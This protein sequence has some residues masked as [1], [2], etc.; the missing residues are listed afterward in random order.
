MAVS[1]EL[2]K[3]L[4]IYVFRASLVIVLVMKIIFL[5]K[6]IRL[7]KYRVII[8]SGG[9][10]EEV[11]IDRTWLRPTFVETMSCW[12]LSAADISTESRI[13][14][15]NG[16]NSSQHPRCISAI[17]LFAWSCQLSCSGDMVMSLPTGRSSTP[18][19][20]L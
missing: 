15:M 2:D 9:S 17:P 18:A 8:L 13:S 12:S 4:K 3:V 10:Q 16:R 14:R 20:I 7:V 6:A 19:T 1:W 11:N 5:R